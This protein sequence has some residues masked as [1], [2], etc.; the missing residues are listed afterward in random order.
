MKTRS[1]GPW[2]AGI[3][4]NASLTRH[5]TTPSSPASWEFSVAA[6]A[7]SAFISS[8]INLPPF[9]LNAMPIQIAEFP[10]AVPISRALFVAFL[11]DE[12]VQNAAILRRE[13]VEPIEHRPRRAWI[14]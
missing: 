3:S 9:L 12:I 8:V 6:F 10:S 11:D 4:L 5:S 14:D 2:R 13:P 7:R 1:K